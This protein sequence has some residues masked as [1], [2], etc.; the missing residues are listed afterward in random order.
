MRLYRFTPKLSGIYG[1]REWWLA[2][3]AQ[4]FGRREARVGSHR[5][6]PQGDCAIL[7]NLS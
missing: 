3:A 5:P 2:P 7:G 6:E 4:F 1:G